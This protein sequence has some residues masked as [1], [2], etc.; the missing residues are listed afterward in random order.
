MLEPLLP[1]SRALRSADRE[2]LREQGSFCLLGAFDHPS[3]S[4]E[5]AEE[6]GLSVRFGARRIVVRLPGEDE[7]SAPRNLRAVVGSV[8]LPCR[9]G[10]VRSVFVPAVTTCESAPTK[11]A[12]P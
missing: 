10:E 9:C 5:E 7:L 12:R 1:L 3:F 11:R 8:Y 4:G 6:G 2:R